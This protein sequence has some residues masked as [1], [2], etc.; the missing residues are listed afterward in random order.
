RLVVGVRASTTQHPSCLLA[1]STKQQPCSRVFV[2][3]LFDVCLVALAR[4]CIRRGG[5][6]AGHPQLSLA[7]STAEVLRKF[8]RSFEPPTSMIAPL[9][10]WGNIAPWLRVHMRRGF[11]SQRLGAQRLA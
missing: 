2:V 10:E 3:C 1:N 7:C 8:C 6:E 4:R 11:L 5:R 9:R